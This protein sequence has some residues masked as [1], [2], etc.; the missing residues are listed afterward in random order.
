MR[1]KRAHRILGGLARDLQTT[2]ADLSIANRILCPLCLTAFSEEAIDLDP[3][4]LT[5][6]HIIPEELGGS[7]IDY[8]HMQGV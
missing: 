6:E 3:P 1:R 8:S 2:T 5:E 4:E 7:L